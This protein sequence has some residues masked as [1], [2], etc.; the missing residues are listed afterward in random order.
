M[1]GIELDALT[2]ILSDQTHWLD[3]L[4]RRHHFTAGFDRVYNSY[5]QGKGK[6][7]QTLFT[8][9]GQMISAGLP[10]LPVGPVGVTVA[11]LTIGANAS[12]SAWVT[13]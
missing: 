8:E 4:D 7:D 2:A 12:M 11:V 10:C 9:V 5:H 13:V 1:P 6:R 3:D